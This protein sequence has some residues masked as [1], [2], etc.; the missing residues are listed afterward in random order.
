MTDIFQFTNVY[1]VRPE[2]TRML[3]PGKSSLAQECL[4]YI[5]LPGNFFYKKKMKK[6]DH[7]FL[8]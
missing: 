8:E 7:F 5:T 6:H 4:E 2:I 1:A 3:D